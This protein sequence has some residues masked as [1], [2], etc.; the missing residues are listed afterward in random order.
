MSNVVCFYHDPC[1]SCD[2]W[3]AA[4]AV[5]TY[6]R[7]RA[8]LFG[9]N[10]NQKLPKV[11]CIDSTIYVVDITPN[12]IKP[13][14]DILEVCKELHIY[15]H[16]EGAGDSLQEIQAFANAKG[17]D[18]KLK[19]IFDTKRSGA[20][21]AWEELMGTLPEV[22]KH[23]DDYDR[24]IKQYPKTDAV[25]AAVRLINKTPESWN[26]DVFNVTL[27]SL[28]VKGQAVLEFQRML[29]NSILQYERMISI[30]GYIV[31]IVNCPDELVNE[32][33]EV[34]TMAFPFAIAYSDQKDQRKYSVRSSKQSSVNI[35]ALDVSKHYGGS[36][37]STAGGFYTPLTDPIIG[38]PS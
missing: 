23:I 33:L 19:I 21:I 27:N 24:W 37:H 4:M 38:N 32:T 18:S 35:T 25:V 30:L 22:V 11:N 36:G 5:H 26:N 15:D 20:R 6:T 31:P 9:L 16:H 12:D 34:L 1:R 28:L 2:G 3:A 13:L 14:L 10:Y 7:R 29:I 17:L 8:L